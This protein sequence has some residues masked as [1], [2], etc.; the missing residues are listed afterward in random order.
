MQAIVLAG[1]QGQRL[2]SMVSGVPKPMAP[3]DGRPFLGYVL[4]LL[5]RKGVTDVILAVGYLG[6]AIAA[7]FGARWGGLALRYAA[8]SEPL[9]TG[10][11]LRNALGLVE[12]FPSWLSTA[13]PIS[14]S[15]SAPCGVPTRPRSRA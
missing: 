4:E 12:R 3:I 9:G 15:I 2:R 8:E 6:D 5:E 10:G 1:G 14:I 7:A 11:A 13:T